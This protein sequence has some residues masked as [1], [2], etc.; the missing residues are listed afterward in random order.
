MSIWQE[1]KKTITWFTWIAT[2]DDN[3]PSRMLIKA[4][5]PYLKS[6]E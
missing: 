2:Q 1:Q 5:C 4:D 6:E 3:K